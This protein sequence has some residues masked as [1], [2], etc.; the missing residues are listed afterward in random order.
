MEI[1]QAYNILKDYY[2]AER[3]KILILPFDVPFWEKMIID[4][5]RELGK[6]TVIYLHGLPAIYNNIDNNRADLLIVWGERI[7]KNYEKIGIESE[8]IMIFGNV[9]Y[10]G[11]I[12]K[13][14]KFDFYNILVISNSSNGAQHGLDVVIQDRGNCIS[15]LYIIENEL[16]NIGVTKA[17]LRLHPSENYKWYNK[18]I[19]TDF[20]T[21]DNEELKSSLE[22]STLVIGP[23]STV[24]LDSIYYGCNYL[25]FEPEEYGESLSKYTLVDPFNGNNKKIP[26]AKTKE[27]LNIILTEKNGIDPSVFEEYNN[28]NY[29]LDFLD[30]L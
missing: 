14:L 23:S 17:K 21:I 18:N 11:Y 30:D 28:L 3:Y 13:K 9:K 22:M 20:Y 29:A 15:Y 19:D 6:K 8:K 5:F 7:K 4:V 2:S 16:K 27:E 12:Q 1:R 25:V 26:V 24:L 10:E